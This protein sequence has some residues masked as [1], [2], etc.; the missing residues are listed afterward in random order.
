MYH[1]FVLNLFLCIASAHGRRIALALRRDGLVI[2]LFSIVVSVAAFGCGNSDALLDDTDTAPPD[3]EDAG[4]NNAADTSPTESS[5][6]IYVETAAGAAPREFVI[7][8]RIAGET[9]YA[10][11]GSTPPSVDDKIS[12]TSDGA[13]LTGAS[14]GT[15]V[16]I[17]AHGYAFVTE[18]LSAS[19]LDRGELTVSLNALPQFEAC[20]DYRTG[21]SADESALFKQWAVPSSTD[22]GPVYAMKF[23]VT[24]ADGDAPKVYFQNTIRNPVHYE[25]V[26]NILGYNLTTSKFWSAAYQGD[27]RQFFAGTVLLYDTVDA[28]S[29]RLGAI[30]SP[31]ALTFFPSD[32]LTA[33]QARHVHRLLE[34]RLGFAS[35]YGN[36]H[37]FYYLPAGTD[38]ET[39]LAT[40]EALFDAW[41]AAWVLRLELYRQISLQIMNT[42]LA[43][44]T[45]RYADAAAIE[46]AVFSAK[47]IAVLP[48]LPT[49]LP[50]VG[51]TVTEEFQ[52]PLSHVNIM[53]KNRGTPNITLADASEL[54][55]IKDLF[56]K[57]VRF[58]VKADGYVLAETSLEE[59]EAFWEENAK[60]PV[61]L[62]S[63]LTFEGLPLFTE[64]GFDDSVRV[65]AKAANL[66]ELR[67]L[68]E[69]GAP[70]GF[71]VP[72]GYYNQFMNENTVLPDG[73]DTASAAC[74]DAGRESD[75]CNRAA[76]RCDAQGGAT[77]AEFAAALLDDEGFASDTPLREACLAVL[78]TLI[79]TG[80]V[81]QS[82]ADALDA[83][84][85]E[86][87]GEK[88]ARL[89]SSTNAEDIPGFSG[90]GLYDSVGA[91]AAGDN[92]ASEEIRR[93][94]AS[95]WNWRAF[96][97][98]SWWGIEHLSVCM[99]V[100][101]SEAYKNEAANGVLITQ[102]I[103]DRNTAGMY[104]NV[105]VGEVSVTNPDG[106]IIPEIFSIISGAEPGTLQAA[107][108]G[109]SSLSPSKPI[110][111]D[112]E[113]SKL[114]TAAMIVQQ[115]FSALYGEDPAFATLD[116]EF[117]LKADSRALIVKQ[118]RPF[119]E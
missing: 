88:K 106:N 57:L 48:I 55:E 85:A 91:Y 20:E 66:A 60:A 41:D 5:V 44:G 50:I 111:S 63:D 89:R 64:I 23:V 114:Y 74:I 116:L 84:V 108:L 70:T 45:L 15:S 22:M 46:T 13:A 49:A 105:Q 79:E 12:C 62:E 35:L 80:T 68:L 53:A 9:V 99:G 2:R 117:K 56:D 31:I 101:V 69:E 95:V 1:V 77:L 115:R 27:P 65:G 107:R 103:A 59:A 47:D 98:R 81:N 119:M 16:T 52:T 100:A 37:R 102:N 58:E 3:T 54:P 109:W 39:D 51:G 38:Q 112:A 97:E 29:D 40:Q 92:R 33:S 94:W 71:A 24:D 32:D 8:A 75:V 43:Y 6:S 118:V 21:F 83:R 36:I 26:R 4:G 30:V 96:E 28:H 7:S 110:L 78:R 11:C 90:A 104:V 42:G 113:I 76:A 34:E 93:V 61:T 87:F 14:D 72:F 17:K 82:F 67:Q 73:C 18:T 86:V 25:F 19:D 10:V